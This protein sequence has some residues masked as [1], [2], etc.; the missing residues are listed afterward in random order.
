MPDSGLQE[1]MYLF[2]KELKVKVA[3]VRVLALSLELAVF[4]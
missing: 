4:T 3:S 2:P 1:R